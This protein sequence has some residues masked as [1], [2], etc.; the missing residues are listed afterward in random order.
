MYTQVTRALTRAAGWGIITRGLGDILQIGIRD[1]Q[2]M[3][4]TH[5]IGKLEKGD[6]VFKGV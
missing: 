2:L 4:V 6:G 1:R 5:S 3:K